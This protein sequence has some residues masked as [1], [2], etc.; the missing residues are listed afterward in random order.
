LNKDTTSKGGRADLEKKKPVLYI[1]EREYL[2]KYSA[3]ELLARIITSHLQK[4][5]R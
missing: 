2:K 3:E 5:G 1:I 4:L